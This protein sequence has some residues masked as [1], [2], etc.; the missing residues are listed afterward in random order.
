MDL[1]IDGL[2][3]DLDNTLFDFDGAFAGVANKFYEQHLNATP[4]T[5]NL[6]LIHI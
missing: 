3:F 5:P 4:N 6:S 2:I 1:A